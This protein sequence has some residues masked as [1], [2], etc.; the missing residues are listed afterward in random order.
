MSLS[1]NVPACHG[2]EVYLLCLVYVAIR[3][4]Q[5]SGSINFQ[6]DNLLAVINIKYIR[7]VGYLALLR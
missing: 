4:I 7:Q 1:H 2:A 5:G 6:F 3:S